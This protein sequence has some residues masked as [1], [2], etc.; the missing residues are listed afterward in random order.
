M[1]IT[2]FQLFEG[3][4][5]VPAWVGENLI[6]TDAIINGLNAAM[7]PD[8]WDTIARFDGTNW[9]QTFKAAPLPS[10]NTLTE[11]VYPSSYWIF[12]GADSELFFY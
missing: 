3:W 6:G 1:T 9:Q 8:T 2:A 10:F 4:R 12:V 7:E 5:E 11:V